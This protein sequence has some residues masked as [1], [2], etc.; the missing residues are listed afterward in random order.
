MPKGSLLA[1]SRPDNITMAN[2][3][4]ANDPLKLLGNDRR[5]TGNA[6]ILYERHETQAKTGLPFPAIQ[7]IR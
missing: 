2:I 1:S 6:W 3:D 5:L 7:L 4:T